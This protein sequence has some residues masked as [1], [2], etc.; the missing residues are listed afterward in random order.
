[1]IEPPAWVKNKDSWRKQCR[2]LVARAKELIEGRIGLIESARE[3]N[4]YGFWFQ[5]TEDPDFMVFHALHR[6]TGQ[7]PL[8]E[9]RKLWAPEGLLIEELK[10][11]SAEMK[12]REKAQKAARNLV[13]KYGANETK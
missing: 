9:V 5:A 8:G 4:K 11:Q 10:I 3:I 13:K 7:I 2:R 6:E 1:M 12:F